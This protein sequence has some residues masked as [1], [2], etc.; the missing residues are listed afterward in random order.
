MNESKRR[1]SEEL[2]QQQPGGEQ[3]E[4]HGLIWQ[5]R[6]TFEELDAEFFKNSVIV[7]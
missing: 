4:E 7:G 1:V 5:F 2:K 6:P 3:D